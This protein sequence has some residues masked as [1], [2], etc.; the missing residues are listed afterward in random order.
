MNKIEFLIISNKFDFTTDYIC[1]ELERRKLK[2]LRLNRDEFENYEIIFKI[3]E[4]ILQVKIENK[5]FILREETLKAIYYR[6]PI[7]LRDNFQPD[8]DV[9]EQLY[10]SQ[11][12]AFI[13]NL[14]LFENVKWVNNPISTFKAENKLLQL[15]YAA[16]IGFAIP[17]TIVTNTN[18]LQIDPQKDYI[19]KTLDTALLRTENKE[20]FIYSSVVKGR[21][22]LDSTLSKSP[23]VLQ[24][25][26][27]PKVDV[28]VTVIGKSVYPVKIEKKGKGIDGDWR[29]EKNNLSYIP[30]NLPLN[31]EQYCVEIVKSLGLAFGG[32]DLIESNGEYYFIEVNPT[33]EWAWLVDSSGLQIYKGICD[34]LESDENYA[35]STY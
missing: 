33:G 18:N 28:R 19:V 34:Y 31:I 23:L 2:Y 20:A 12:T 7:Y 1:L 26:I 15:K 13:R 17:G 29:L 21:E 35:L 6:A 32:I 25:Y 10:R 27:Y 14:T 8:I 5:N 3:N 30:F 4:L 24:D 9:E 11:W 22:V 16:R